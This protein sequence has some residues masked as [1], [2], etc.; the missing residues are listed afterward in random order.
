[1]TK[2]VLGTGRGFSQPDQCQL[3]P[4]VGINGNG[5]P[6]QPAGQAF[7]IQV[8]VTT[9]VLPPGPGSSAGPAVASGGTRCDLQPLRQVALQ[10]LSLQAPAL[11]R[12]KLTLLEASM[13]FTP[14]Y[15]MD[16][17][18]VGIFFICSVDF[19]G[20][21]NTQV[22][23]CEQRPR[24]QHHPNPAGGQHRPSRASPWRAWTRRQKTCCWWKETGRDGDVKRAWFSQQKP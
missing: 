24:P 7:G 8:T 20:N 3:F 4:L 1:M 15:V 23:G 12:F 14:L 18:M 13:N 2:R 16:S 5:V 10:V 11:R 22:N 9:L 21:K 19:F 6:K 17:I